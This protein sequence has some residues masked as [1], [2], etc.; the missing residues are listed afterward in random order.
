MKT[1]KIQEHVQSKEAVKEFQET[2]DAEQFFKRLGLPTP[3]LEILT[4]ISHRTD[5][6]A[7]RR[8]LIPKEKQINQ[9]VCEWCG[10]QI[11]KWH[12]KND[13]SDGQIKVLGYCTTCC[14]RVW[15]RPL[16]NTVI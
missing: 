15:S 13:L 5:S 1:N 16:I 8:S 10:N 3:T 11:I 9:P 2:G 6:G 4:N 14:T 12:G 7:C